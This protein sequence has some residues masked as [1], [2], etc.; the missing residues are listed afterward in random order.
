MRLIVD[1]TPGAADASPLV[2]IC[3]P[4]YRRPVELREA[5]ASALAQTVQDIEVVV[6]DDGGNHQD[7]AV[8]FADPRLR[9]V[10]NESNLGM[11]GN[12]ERA[13]SLARGRYVMLLMDDDR[14]LPSFVERCL[15]AFGAEPAIDVVFTNHLFDDGQHVVERARLLPAG[16]YHAFLPHLLR[17]IPV[18]ICATLMGRTV[19]DKVL[20]LPDIHAADLALQIRAA[21]AGCV[22]HYIDESLMV[23]RVHSGQLSGELEFR[24]HYVKLWRLFAF[25]AGSEEEQLRRWRLA[26]ALLSTTAAQIQRG[27]IDAARRSAAEAAEL[28]VPSASLTPRARLVAMLARSKVGMRSGASVFRLLRFLRSRGSGTPTPRS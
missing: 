3:I 19:W 15:E 24:D 26:E 22:F 1:A 7:V 6:T 11:A 12:W 5:I 20:P 17:E 28:G 18:A 9:Y 14:L 16:T 10:L 13:L 21:Q 23:Y 25:E 8:E 2:S 27:E 4:A